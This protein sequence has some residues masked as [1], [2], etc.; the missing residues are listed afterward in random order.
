MLLT[1]T[2]HVVPSATFT[3]L[4]CELVDIL[5]QV[6]RWLAKSHDQL[7][8]V[9]TGQKQVRSIKKGCLRHKILRPRH[10]LTVKT[11][12][13]KTENTHNV[14]T[15]WQRWPSRYIG[16]GGWHQLTQTFPPLP[17]DLYFAA[18]E[19]TI[20]TWRGGVGYF[21]NNFATAMLQLHVCLGGHLQMFKACR[22]NA[23][24][25]RG[26]DRLKSAVFLYTVTKR[27]NSKFIQV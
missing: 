10:F 14:N 22:K 18:T 25:V 19:N 21:E 13:D 27:Y 23:L 2:V 24:C 7:R 9:K 3:F 20:H 17:K 12:T 5:D 15:N 16:F 8:R 26:I 6:V 1:S 11:M 4:L